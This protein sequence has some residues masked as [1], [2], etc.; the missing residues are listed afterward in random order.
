[1][2]LDLKTSRIINCFIRLE[3]IIFGVEYY[4]IKEYVI[5]LVHQVL[6]QTKVII[7]VCELS[8]SNLPN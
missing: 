8:V 2:I 5:S 6:A 3:K 7:K 4:K 1:M